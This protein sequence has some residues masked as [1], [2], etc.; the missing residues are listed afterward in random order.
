MY[1]NSINT[2]KYETK[3]TEITRLSSAAIYQFQTKKII[4]IFDLYFHCIIVA[5]LNNKIII[6]AIVSLVF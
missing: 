2:Y 5:N 6:V 3:V 1:K 4:T